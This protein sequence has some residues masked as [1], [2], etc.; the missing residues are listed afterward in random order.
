MLREHKIDGYKCDLY[1]KDTNTAIEVKSLLSF[2]QEALFPTVY[3]ERAVK[4]LQ[5]LSNLL[6]AGYRVCFI[7]VSLSRTVKKMK[8]NPEIVDFYDL[9]QECVAKGMTFRGA[10]LGFN[11]GELDIKGIVPIE[12]GE[13]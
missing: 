9:F 11:K 4:Q 12:I 7:M 2:E 1:I 6:E 3:S 8:I 10:V 5:Q 13:K